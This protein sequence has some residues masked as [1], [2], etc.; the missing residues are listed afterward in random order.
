LSRLCDFALLADENVAPE[1]VTE[2]RGMS[3][4]ISDIKER[5][6]LGCSDAEI[7]RIAAEEDR[8]IITHDADFGTLALASGAKT[9]GILY[10][11]P[12]H[13]SANYTLEILSAALYLDLDLE[14]PFICVAERK[15]DRVRV[16]VR[17]M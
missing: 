12:G 1:I 13:I 4:D 16:R 9:F 14:P 11:R 5:Q 8:V 2:L 6:L 17:S 15:Q 3:L 10:I 7:L